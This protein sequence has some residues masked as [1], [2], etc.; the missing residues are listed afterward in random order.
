MKI[1]KHLLILL[2]ITYSINGL[3]QD[4]IS[5]DTAKID[6]SYY[7]KGNID[8]NLLLATEKGYPQEVIRLLNKG[9]NV[10]FKTWEGVTP[11]MY[12]VQNQDTNMIKILVLNGADLDKKPNSG[13]P[14]LINSVI[15][16]NLYIAEYL[17]RNGA[18]INITDNSGSTPLMYASAYGHFI[19]LDM[20]LYYEAEAD[21]KNKSGTDAL[22]LAS[23]YGDYDI[24][25]RLIEAGTDV[26]ST[27]NKGL[28]ALHCAVQNGYSNLA[29]LLINNGAGVNAKTHSGYSPIAIAVEQK[30]LE[31]VILLT[32]KGAN[33]NEK[34]SLTENPVS[35]ACKHKNKSI[36]RFLLENNGKRNLLPSISQYAFGMNVDFNLNDFMAGVNMGLHDR[37]YNT[38]LNYGYTIRPWR[39]RVLED[40]SE[41]LS[42]QYWEIRMALFLSLD[43]KYN[44]IK[45]KDQSALGISVGA[46]ELYT[47]GSYRGSISKPANKFI[48]AP[49]SGVF[50]ENNYFT[51][52]VNYEYS[53]FNLYK[54]NPGRLNLSFVYRITRKK[55]NYFPKKTDEF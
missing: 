55:N 18:D 24:G 30:D 5:T 11:L 9:A 22:M 51:I 19:I 16:G 6:T 52:N 28:S 33:V 20:L 45:F 34:I 29:E 4:S 7:T 31:S 35:L 44:I 10:N 8:Y 21:R 38:V 1:Q 13:I 48:F 15:T 12:A 39:K 14:A 41:T 25:A 42:Y 37:K 27:D 32:E 23:Y 53:N 43:K 26:N 46:K 17:I 49:K 50:W 3:S 36:K 40:V 2:L 47:F 54:V